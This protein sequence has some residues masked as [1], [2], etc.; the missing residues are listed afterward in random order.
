M[1]DLDLALIGNCAF[2]A[3]VD[4]RARVVWACVPRID[5]DPIFC[6][7]L[8]EDADAGFFEIAIE[9][10]ARAEQCYEKNSAILVTR[11]HDANGG[12]VEVVDFAPRFRQYDRV[13][14]PISMVRRLRPVAG[15]PRVVVRIRPRAGYGGARPAVTQGSNHLRY[16]VGEHVLRLTTDA[17][18]SLLLSETPFLLDH[19]VNLVLGPDEP[20]TRGCAEITRD[21]EEKTGAYWREWARYLAIPFEWQDAV[22]RAAITLKL[23]AVEETG[24][25]VAAVTTSVPEAAHSGRNWDY[26]Y[27][28]LRD[29]YFVVHALNRLGATRTMEDYIRYIVNVVAGATDGALQPVYG[30]A[31]ETRLDEHVVETLAGYRGM[32]PVRRGNLAYRQIQHDVYGSVILAVTQAF[33][34]RRL[35]LHGDVRLFRRLE[36][37]GERAAVC[38]DQPDAGIWELRGTRRVHTF[39]SLMCWAGCDRLARIA[40]QLGLDDRARYWASVAARIRSVIWSEAWSERLGAFVGTFGG[41]EMDASLLLMQALGFVAADDPRFV[42]TVARIESEL[43]RGDHLFRYAERDD[44]GYPETAF[45]VCT[46]WYIEALAAMGRTDEARR[47]FE[48]VLGCRNHVGL[49]SEDLDPETGELWGNMPQTYSMVGLISAAMRLSRTWEEAF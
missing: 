23:C 6:S 3:L 40:R 30:V 15:D 17:P 47:L 4:R 33:F 16:V 18:I 22:I 34:D 10:F 7:L 24:A 44:F 32:G 9:G 37:L 42:G 29:A 19:E 28:W 5:G 41:E 46:F 31:M 26:R 20:L 13:F 45:T 39:S 36:I 35:D 48:S 38:Y 14:R 1:T 11:L 27:C 43:R 21:F 25:V 12:I 49:L 2:A 8:D